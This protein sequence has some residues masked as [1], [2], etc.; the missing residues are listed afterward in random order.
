MIKKK[1]PCSKW[2][3]GLSSDVFYALSAFDARLGNIDL[4][5]VI[6]QGIGI[7]HTDRLFCLGLLGH[8]H[9]S[10]AFRHA[11]TLVFD[12]VH[13]SD[14]TGLCEQGID[15]ILRGRFVQVSYINSGI[16]FSTS[17]SGTAGNKNDRNPISG[18]AVK[19]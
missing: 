5:F 12:Q 10:E 11:G 6:G 1:N 8:G 2:N 19:V 7:E 3:E 13:R 18:S 14:G 17:F 16:Q 9:K 4:K 15:F